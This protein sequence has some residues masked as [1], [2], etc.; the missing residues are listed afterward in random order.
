MGGSLLSQPQTISVGEAESLVRVALRH[1][2]SPLSSK[3]CAVERLDQEG[4][5][6]VQ[7]YYSFGPF[8]DYPN[9]AVR[10]TFGLYVVSPR[11]GDVWEF[12]RCEWFKF[13]RLQRLQLSIM[14]RTRATEVE[15]LNYRRKTGCWNGE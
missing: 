4:K 14:R 10:T 13:P 9:T 2:G 7:G 12:N 6:F 1:E 15:E 3:Y 11:T 5:P 8:C